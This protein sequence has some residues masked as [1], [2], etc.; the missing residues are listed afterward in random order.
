[1]RLTELDLRSVVQ[2][3]IEVW[4]GVS[5]D[6]EITVTQPSGPVQVNCDPVRIEQVVCNLLSNA[7][8]YSPSGGIVDVSLTEES[9]AA[10]IRVTDRGI[11]IPKEELRKV[12]EPFRRTSI[13]RQQIAGIGL[14]LSVSLRIVKDHGGTIDVDSDPSRG[15][16]FQ[17]HA[18]AGGN[19]NPSGMKIL[20]PG[21]VI[22]LR[23]RLCA[24]RGDSGP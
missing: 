9:G 20:G 22:R 10:V 8:K 24:G 15:T 18:S 1:M 14:G 12:F 5:S 11:G 21:E 17:G 19:R 4:Q 23:P 16:Y 2:D 13:A 3:V 7:I 6:H